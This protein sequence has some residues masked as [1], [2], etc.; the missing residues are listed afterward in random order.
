MV[1]VELDDQVNLSQKNMTQNISVKATI[2]NTFVLQE[3]KI[4]QS[5]YG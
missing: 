3:W 5:T 1:F 2:D 4:T